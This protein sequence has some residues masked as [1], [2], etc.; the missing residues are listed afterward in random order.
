MCPEC[1][2]MKSVELVMVQWSVARLSEV[3]EAMIDTV[4]SGEHGSR[5]I[6]PLH[7]RD[8]LFT[9]CLHKYW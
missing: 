6:Q 4:I 1:D 5:S 7:S 2:A 8:L 3:G 9:E